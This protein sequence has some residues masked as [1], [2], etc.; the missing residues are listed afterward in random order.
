[1]SNVSQFSSADGPAQEQEP[2]ETAFDVADRDALRK[3]LGSFATGVTVVTV[4]GKDSLHGMTANAFSSVSL[5]PPLVLI[6]I[7]RDAVMH[8]VLSQTGHFGVS[9]LAAEQEETARHFADRWRALGSAEF[10]EVDWDPGPRTGVPLITAA[11]ARFECELW[12][13]Y[14][15][16]DH[17]I[18]LGRL[19]SLNRRDDGESL[20]F[21]D[22]RFCHLDFE[23][24]EVSA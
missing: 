15:G 19:I 23:R 6:C 4:G 5:D 18:F 11:L 12:R 8:E 16:G 10:D 21:F 9:V 1:M 2:A 22:G 14:D 3:V 24:S 13:S 7:G 20:V 17:T